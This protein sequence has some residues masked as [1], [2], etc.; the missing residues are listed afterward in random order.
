MSR[1]PVKATLCLRRGEKQLATGTQVYTI[2]RPEKR[3]GEGQTGQAGGDH[4]GRITFISS[5]LCA[6][7]SC[8]AEQTVSKTVGSE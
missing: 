1:E 6:T 5:L 2:A 3:E 8:S 4:T 7:L